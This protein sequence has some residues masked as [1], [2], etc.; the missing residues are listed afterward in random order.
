MQHPQDVL[1]SLLIASWL[2]VSGIMFACSGD[3]SDPWTPL[4]AATVEP[5]PTIPALPARTPRVTPTAPVAT[6][7]PPSIAPARSLPL[8][9]LHAR[10]EG[11][12]YPGDRTGICWPITSEPGAKCH[13]MTG[14]YAGW[15][16]FD[17][18]PAIRLRGD[19]EFRVILSSS[20]TPKDLLKVTVSV[21]WRNPRVYSA[22]I[23]C[24]GTTSLRATS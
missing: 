1:L 20:N 6:P 2:L 19:E 15:E 18:V 12:Y 3:P 11:L 22:G 4:P 5:L 9:S 17:E 10:H 13:L 7:T 16:G 21:C 24:S 23:C 14:L 8:P